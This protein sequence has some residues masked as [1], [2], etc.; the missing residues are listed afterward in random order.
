MDF[1]I[2][3]HDSGETYNWWHSVAN[4]PTCSGTQYIAARAKIELACDSIR[5]QGPALSTRIGLAD[6]RIHQVSEY[7]NNIAKVLLTVLSNTWST[8]VM[9][10]TPFPSDLFQAHP[11][12]QVLLSR[13]HHRPGCRQW[14]PAQTTLAE[15]ARELNADVISECYLDAKNYR[16]DPVERIDLVD[17][18]ANVAGLLE[19]DNIVNVENG[20]TDEYNLSMSIT[21]NFKELKSACPEWQPDTQAVRSSKVS[22]ITIL[23]I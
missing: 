2:R 8:M 11:H 7:D 19:N 18:S 20:V 6:R 9:R 12:H 17:F 23:D 15:E 16:C 4:W 3:V 22:S 1:A 10:T 13:K 21:D 5:E 14:R